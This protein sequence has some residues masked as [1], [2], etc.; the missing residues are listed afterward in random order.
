MSA[1]KRTSLKQIHAVLAPQEV[2]DVLF[3]LCM[4]FGF[5][6]TPVEIEKLAA[7]PPGDIETF[8]EAALVAEGYDFTKSDSLCASVRE[9]VAQAFIDHQS[10]NPV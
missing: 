10:K 1:R 2:R 3:R 8:T 9:V 4:K 7:S 6:L 5:C